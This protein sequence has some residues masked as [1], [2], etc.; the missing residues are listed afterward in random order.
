ML[1]VRS[2]LTRHGKNCARGL[3]WMKR[4]MQMCALQVRDRPATTLRFRGCVII[5]RRS[6][7]ETGRDMVP[8]VEF[9]RVVEPSDMHSWKSA[10]EPGECR[11]VA[12]QNIQTDKRHTLRV[13]RKPFGPDRK[14]SVGFDEALDEVEQGRPDWEG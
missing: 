4:R 11:G 2:E 5:D 1:R 12:R 7:D 10:F 6:L 14:R 8:A 13:T 3:G 9:Y